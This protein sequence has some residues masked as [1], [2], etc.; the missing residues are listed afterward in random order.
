MACSLVLF[1]FILFFQAPT[2]ALR[3]QVIICTISPAPGPADA[4]RVAVCAGTRSAASAGD[5]ASPQQHRSG[6]HGIVLRGPSAAMPPKASGGEKVKFKII[7]ASDPKL[8]FRVCVL[9]TVVSRSTQWSL[10]ELALIGTGWRLV[11]GA[12]PSRGSLCSVSL[13]SLH[14]PLGCPVTACFLARSLPPYCGCFSFLLCVTPG[15]YK[16][17]LPTIHRAAMCGARTHCTVL[18]PAVCAG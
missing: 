3:A 17:L 9:A 11:V 4:A 7:L 2:W 18:L 13:V 8:P 15:R 14:R 12:A 6:S 16:W 10:W 1:F 5:G